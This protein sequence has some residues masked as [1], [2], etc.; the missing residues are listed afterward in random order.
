MFIIVLFF[1]IFINY[2]QGREFMNHHDQEKLEFIHRVRDDW[3]TN[4][5]KRQ[6]KHR[7]PSKLPISPYAIIILNL[8]LDIKIFHWTSLLPPDQFT[9]FYIED[10]HQVDEIIDFDQFVEMERNRNHKKFLSHAGKIQYKEV[11]NGTSHRFIIRMNREIPRKHSFRWMSYLRGEVCAWDK[12]MF[13]VGELTPSYKFM[14]F[15]EEDVFIPTPQSFLK[16]HEKMIANRYDLASNAINVSYTRNSWIWR[17][18]P[19]I[20]EEFIP[21]PYYYGLDCATGFSHRLLTEL[22]KFRLRF[23]RFDFHEAMIATVALKSNV[24]IYRVPEISKTIRYRQSWNCSDFLNYSS[25]WFHPVKNQSISLQKCR[26]QGIWNKEW[27]RFN[28][29]I[30]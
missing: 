16:V 18:I 9:V 20:R 15:F 2:G 6:F 1:V 22:L 7:L 25:Y 23:H 19:T 17:H 29:N 13:L 8:K 12:A 4:A 10:F 14:W 27:D 30:F 24:S 26:E 11:K 28:V 3:N 5:V 21:L